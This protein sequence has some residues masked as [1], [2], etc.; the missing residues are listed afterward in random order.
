MY[1]PGLSGIV[2]R[3]VAMQAM[4]GLRP[5]GLTILIIRAHMKV[6]IGSV[7]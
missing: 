5:T 4:V 7:I 1:P 2:L 6:E 3:L